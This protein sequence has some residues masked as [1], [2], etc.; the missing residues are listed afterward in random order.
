MSSDE[1]K[2]CPFCGEEIKYNATRCIHCHSSLDKESMKNIEMIREKYFS[3]NADQDRVRQRQNDLENNG[4]PNLNEDAYE[5]DKQDEV[6]FTL[7]RE[8]EIMLPMDYKDFEIWANK[9][10]GIL[11]IFKCEE[12]QLS[13]FFKDLSHKKILNLEDLKKIWGKYYE[14]LNVPRKNFYFFNRKVL[15]II[16][17]PPLVKPIVLFDTFFLAGNTSNDYIVVNYKDLD[18]IKG[19]SYSIEYRV[20]SLSKPLVKKLIVLIKES[21]VIKIHKATCNEN[22]IANISLL[23]NKKE[24]VYRNIQGSI[25]FPGVYQTGTKKCLFCEEDIKYNAN[26]CRFC[27]GS[28]SEQ[29][30]GSIKNNMTKYSNFALLKLL[31]IKAFQ[32][33]E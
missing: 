18:H 29:K 30:G 20:L 1:Y 17:A 10:K 31:L 11:S 9:K 22:N 15:G 5:E 14:A 27:M 24:E 4:I 2:I 8:D 13:Q 26:K 12:I 23:E 32:M 21:K 3:N 6:K 19:S 33:L 28:L 25:Y 16:T 7:N